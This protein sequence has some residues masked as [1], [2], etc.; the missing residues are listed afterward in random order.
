M[1]SQKIG[2]SMNSNELTNNCNNQACS[3]IFY[4]PLF[5]YYGIVGFLSCIFTDIPRL[6]F[7]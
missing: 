3:Y 5:K 7:H 4:S 6:I 2:N 1:L